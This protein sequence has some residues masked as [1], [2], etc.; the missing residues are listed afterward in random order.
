[1]LACLSNIVRK[2]SLYIQARRIR[3]R[4]E[5]RT[6]KIEYMQMRTPHPSGNKSQKSSD[7]FPLSITVTL[8]W[9]SSLCVSSKSFANLCMS[10]SFRPRTSDPIQTDKWCT[11][12]PECSWLTP[13]CWI[14][15]FAKMLAK[16]I[17][18]EMTLEDYQRENVLGGECRMKTASSHKSSLSNILNGV[19]RSGIW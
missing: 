2:N 3:T 1:M 6:S 18:F 12:L 14:N 17:N 9:P 10:A 13:G 19:A 8:I 5:W 16:R 11:H 4:C 15:D 7:S